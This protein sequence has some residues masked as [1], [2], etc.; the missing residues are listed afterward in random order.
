M[1]EPYAHDVV[2]SLPVGAD[3]AAPGAAVTVELCGNWRHDPPCPFAPHHTRAHREGD[4]LHL[5]VLFAA[6]PERERDV[7]RR[8]DAALAAGRVAGPDGGTTRWQLRSSA[9]GTVDP[10]EADHASRLVT[11]G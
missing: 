9:A 7:R 6:E 3:E 10:D 5:R 8:I 2:L 11:D 1:R 4:A